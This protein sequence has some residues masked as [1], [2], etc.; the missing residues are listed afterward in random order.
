MQTFRV[1][2]LE[3]HMQFLHILNL[4]SS[5]GE[6]QSLP[7]MSERWNG[8]TYGIVKCSSTTKGKL[9][10]SVAEAICIKISVVK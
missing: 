5:V 2:F 10:K 4:F 6:V 8:V 1:S 9:Y 7:L 3:E